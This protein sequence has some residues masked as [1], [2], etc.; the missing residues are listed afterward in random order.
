M[1]A[2]ERISADNRS[3]GIAR[4]WKYCSLGTRRGKAEVASCGFASPLRFYGHRDNHALPAPGVDFHFSKQAAS[5]WRG[6]A[7]SLL[8]G[9]NE[10]R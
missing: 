3:Y 5:N 2:K 1:S 8:P 6:F 7:G 9:L 10:D 4:A